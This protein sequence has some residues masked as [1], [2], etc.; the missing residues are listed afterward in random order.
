MN[1]P[2]CKVSISED[3]HRCS[4]CGRRL[5]NNPGPLLAT[6]TAAALRLDT[7]LTTYAEPAPAP[8]PRLEYTNADAP[9][10]S[11]PRHSAA[12]QS[13]LFSIREEGK[14]RSIDGRLDGLGDAPVSAK[15]TRR[16]P[17]ERS[18]YLPYQGVLEF[19]PANGPAPRTLPTSVEA[20]I[21]CDY[22]V[23]TRTHRM[24]AGLI[25]FFIVL[26]CM[27]LFLGII[28]LGC[29]GMPWVTLDKTA[30]AMIGIA[31]G[32]LGFLYE[33]YWTMAG[34]PSPGM[35]SVGLRLVHFDGNVPSAMDNTRRI[36]GGL[37][38]VMAAFIGL[39]WAF[40]DEEC[41]T[42]QDHISRTFPTPV[43]VQY[44][45]RR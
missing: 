6:R 24:L 29:E 9:K 28:Y 38:S 22:P 21:Y 10:A 25:D 37:L 2:N 39:A 13:S 17:V 43:R 4:N 5:G 44:G 20:V 34:V 15:R 26:G 27:L 23:A 33:A 40:V 41:L 18:S 1:C 32:L 35:E 11:R 14:V 19:P 7:V 42:W 30:I 8:R 12:M 36:F 45:I 31:T 3:D 16:Q